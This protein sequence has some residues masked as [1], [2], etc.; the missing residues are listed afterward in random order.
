MQERPEH[1]SRP[2][3]RIDPELRQRLI[4][5]IA[6]AGVAIAALL[7]GLAVIDRY[8]VAPPTPV[9]HALKAS[10]TPPSVKPPEVPPAVA[11]IVAAPVPETSAEPEQRAAP[12]ITQAAG[13]RSTETTRQIE[14]PKSVAATPRLPTQPV[15]D[16]TPVAEDDRPSPK[17]T[18]AHA[19]PSKPLARDNSAPKQFVFQMGIFNDVANAQ[20]LN[21]KLQEG[22][23]PSRIEARVQVGPFNTREE[24]E[25][26]RKKLIAL[27]IKPGMLMPVRK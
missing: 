9:P 1:A 5:R 16:K 27:G 7:G 23:V 24:A 21:E 12:T 13:P 20:R 2:E 19:A 8:Y 18:E 25:A 26:A 15:P 14:T 10:L 6:M 17:V 3:H 22:G 11:P 4:K